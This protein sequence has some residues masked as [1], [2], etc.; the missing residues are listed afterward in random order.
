M[1]KRRLPVSFDTD[2][3]KKKLPPYNNSEM[4]TRIEEVIHD[5]KD[6][7]LMKYRLIDGLNLADAAEKL[8]MPFSTA[9]DHYYRQ[10][11]VLFPEM[12]RNDKRASV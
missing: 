4:N 5:E 2:L 7:L 1:R 10:L 6:R 12:P 11:S 3:L 9:R 8:D